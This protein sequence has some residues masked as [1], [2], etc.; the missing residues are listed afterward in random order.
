MP[1]ISIIVPCYNVEKYLNRCVD[2]LVNQTIQDIEI[3]LVDDGSRDKVPSMCD[4]WSKQDSRIKVV[5]KKNEGLGYARNTGLEHATGEF[6]AFIDS[7]DY[8]DCEAYNEAFFEATQNHADAVLWGFSKEIKP[9]VWKKYICEKKVMQK[10]CIVDYMLNIIASPPYIKEERLADMAVW[11]GIYKKDLIDSYRIRFLSE[12][13]VVCEDI[14]FDVDF[15][16]RANKLVVLDKAYSFYC[17][18][19]NSLSS[20]F[21]EEKFD[22]FKKLHKVL[23][24]KLKENEFAK[25][26]I[27]RFFIGFTRSYI[28]NLCRT[29]VK[30]KN[31]IIQK[32][33]FDPIWDDIKRTYKTSYLPFYQRVHLCLL[34][35][36]NV[37]LLKYF[38]F[39]ISF[40]KRTR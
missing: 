36:K 8:I 5:H 35:R 7:D 11:H 37:M 15:L 17:L 25:Q 12:R 33:V 10:E 13:D 20:T 30:R 32:V 26:R 19:E 22:N 34:Y 31:D 2:S 38:M 3:I 14:P 29:N 16:S 24:D 27:D 28:L 40:V 39:F 21:K 23:C 4:D 1:K 6:V 9:N 18:N